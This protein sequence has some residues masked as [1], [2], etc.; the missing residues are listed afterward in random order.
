MTNYTGIS[1]GARPKGP[2]RLIPIALL[3]FLTPG[4][5]AA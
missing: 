1:S 5:G 3:A 2:L 4:S